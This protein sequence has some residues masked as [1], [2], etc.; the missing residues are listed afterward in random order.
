MSRFLF[1][2]STSVLGLALLPASAHAGIF[3]TDPAEGGVYV[4]GFVGISLPS[5]LNFEGIQAPE[6][7]SPGAAGAP[8]NVR[9]DLDNDVYFGGAVGARL[10]FKYWKYFQPRLELELS[11]T[12]NS[13]S[14]GSF[15]G[16]TQ[17]FSG[18]Q[19]VLFGFLNSSSDII[20]EDDQKIVPFI[21]GGL[22]FADVDSNI[23]YAGGGATSP[24]F[25]VI[26]SSSNFVT[27]SSAG[28]TFKATQKNDLFLE[29]R[30][31]TIYDVDQERRFIA[32]GADIFN[33]DVDDNVS[34]F[35][36]TVGTRFNF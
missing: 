25:G 35:T 19:S 21:G 12:D 17:T 24:N 20:W 31:Y 32:D 16:G 1:A 4:S 14:E 26:G 28:L 27:H 18:D 2:I 8:A 34:G 10:P 30:Y 3:D 5:E 13:V 22:G 15:N 9:A 11:Y 36:L 23:L 33:A 29:A 7:G 6:T